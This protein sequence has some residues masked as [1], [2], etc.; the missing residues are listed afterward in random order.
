MMIIMNFMIFSNFENL[1]NK[2]NI[3]RFKIDNEII[4]NLFDEKSAFLGDLVHTSKGGLWAL[5][6]VK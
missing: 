4:S 2:N 1:E 3:T 6:T 5:G